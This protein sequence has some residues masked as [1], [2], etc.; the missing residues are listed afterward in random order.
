MAPLSSKNMKKALRVIAVLLTFA[1]PTFDRGMSVIKFFSLIHEIKL[2]PENVEISLILKQ[3]VW[4]G[5]WKVVLYHTL[6]VAL[7]ALWLS[8][9]MFFYLVK[10]P[11]VWPRR[12]LNVAWWVFLLQGILALIFDQN[13]ILGSHIHNMKIITLALFATW[14]AS[15][16]L[17]PKVNL[18][19][20]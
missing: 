2:H 8:A 15:R 3:I 16:L 4:I 9:P 20:E 19:R 1:F 5:Y 17:D 12:I 7:I 10:V 14:F 18:E 11:T 13:D 6:N